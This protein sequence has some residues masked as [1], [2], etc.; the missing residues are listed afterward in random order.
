MTSQ[1]WYEAAAAKIYCIWDNADVMTVIFLPQC[2]DFAIDVTFPVTDSLD[3]DFVLEPHRNKSMLRIIECKK[4]TMAA[5]IPKYRTLLR[6]KYIYAI[7]D[8]RISDLATYCDSVV[9]LQKSQSKTCK[10]TLV[11]DENDLPSMSQHGIPQIYFDQMNV[12]HTHLSE[13]RGLLTKHDDSYTVN[14]IHAPFP[15]FV[16][17]YLSKKKTGMIGENLNRNNSINII[18]KACLDNHHQ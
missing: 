11:V 3:L 16:F 12:I 9:N 8:I 4:G 13:L 1:H 5:Q 15:K 18:F 2:Y 17:V 14:H 6:Y 10:F 7:N